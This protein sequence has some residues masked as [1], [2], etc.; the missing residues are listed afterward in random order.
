MEWLYIPMFTRG[1]SHEQFFTKKTKLFLHV[2]MQSTSIN[3]ML[4]LEREGCC[5]QALF[6]SYPGTSGCSHC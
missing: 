1:K 4:G 2:Q 6:M 3:P 5:I